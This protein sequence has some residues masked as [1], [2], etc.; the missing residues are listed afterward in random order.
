MSEY[1]VDGANGKPLVIPKGRWYMSAKARPERLQ[2]NDLSREARQV[3]AC[4]ELGTMGFSQ[5][6]ALMRKGDRDV[7]MTFAFIAE[8]TGL[9]RQ[10]IHDRYWPE[11]EREGL[12]AKRAINPELPLQQGN[13]ELISWAE[14]KAPKQDSVP[15]R[16]YRIPEWAPPSW[17]DAESTVGRFLKRFKVESTA[18]FVP[19]RGYIEEVEAAAREYEK[20]ETSLR[21]LLDLSRAP[22]AYKEE[23]N[24][25][26]ER[27][28]QSPSSSSS[29]AQEPTTTTEEPEPEPPKPTEP[30]PPPASEPEPEPEEFHDQLKTLFQEAGK[31]VPVPSQSRAAA[32]AVNGDTEEFLAWLGNERKIRK[33]QHPGALPS[34]TAEFKEWQST[35]PIPPK[36]PPDLQQT[37]AV[38]PK[39]NGTGFL[40]GYKWTVLPAAEAHAAAG[41]GICECPEGDLVRALVAT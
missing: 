16:G 23:R 21:A 17:S 11:L 15:A 19:A 26:N 10:H 28:I 27:N 3:Y 24:E 31:P 2:R 6:V 37:D 5:E 12:V 39:C 20:A 36:E 14:P 25:R 1:R 40:D 18:D 22:N 9:R 13:I 4:L 8:R 7:P 29:L 34:L 38:C 33:I 41:A 30:P 35:R 32:V